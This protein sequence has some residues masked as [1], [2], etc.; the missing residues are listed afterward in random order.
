MV[1]V[2]LLASLSLSGCYNDVESFVEASAKLDCKRM[3][4]CNNSAF[5]NNHRG[6][7]A[8]CRSD[9]E[10]AYFDAVDLLEGLGWEYD[11]DG[12]KECISAKRSLRNDCSNDA[13]QEIAESCNDVADW[14]G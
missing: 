5:V 2:P 10:D 8:E 13:S 7:M 4:E 9:L 11:P 3:R 12:G 14:G 6:E 1:A